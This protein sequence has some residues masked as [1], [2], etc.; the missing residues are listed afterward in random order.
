MCERRFSHLLL[1]KTKQQ[2][3]LVVE[4][5][6]R[7]RCLKPWH[8]L[9][10]LWRRSKH[11][12]HTEYDT[13]YLHETLWQS[14]TPVYI[15]SIDSIRCR[16]SLWWLCTTRRVLLLR[17]VLW[18]NLIKSMMLLFDGL[19]VKKD[20]PGRGTRRL[21][22]LVKGTWGWKGWEPLLYNLERGQSKDSGQ[23][24]FRSCS[25][26]SMQNALQS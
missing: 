16:L 7:S 25:Q 10:S 5:D 8:V 21:E 12:H 17:S 6:L 15:Y 3:R 14:K 22:L 19:Y 11:S 2:N 20:H 24:F 9:R 4:N 18:C 23:A 1:L 13:L 26:K